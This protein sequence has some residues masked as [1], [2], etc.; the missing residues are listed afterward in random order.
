MSHTRTWY[1]KQNDTSPDLQVTI[2]D[3]DANAVDVSGS[4]I[5]FNMSAAGVPK[6]VNQSCSIVSGSDGTVKY[7]WQSGDTD[8]PG[9]YEGEFQV[10]F[11]GGAIGT[12]PNS[13]ALKLSIIITK[14]LG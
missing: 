9:I 1:M 4:T 2:L 14:E 8:T 10:T 13:D 7:V 6:V 3:G 5:V 11:V 12:Y